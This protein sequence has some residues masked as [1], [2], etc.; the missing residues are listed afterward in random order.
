MPAGAGGGPLR[1]RAEHLDGVLARAHV[2]GDAPA[3]VAADLGV[4]PNAVYLAKSRVLR[5]LRE[6]FASLADFGPAG[7]S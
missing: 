2:E 6:E 5:R 3:D 1:V 4:T 7:I